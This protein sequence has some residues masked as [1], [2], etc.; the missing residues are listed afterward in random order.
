MDILNITFAVM[1]IGLGLFGWLAPGYTLATLDLHKGDSSM[2]PSEI[3]ASAGA[4]FIG[5]GCGALFLA[6]PTAFAM[7]G[8]AWAGA[9]VGRA[10][11]LLLDGQTSKKWLFFGV[12][13]AVALGAIVNNL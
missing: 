8:F 4:L 7:L 2:G 9:A 6:T 1:S 13:A 12:E 3:R 5:L 11:S 10:T